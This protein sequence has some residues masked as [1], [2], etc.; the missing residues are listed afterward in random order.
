MLAGY[1]KK[2][3]PQPVPKC[4]PARDN[5]SRSRRAARQPVARNVPPVRDWAIIAAALLAGAALAATAAGPATWAW[6]G[7]FVAANFLLAAVALLAWRRDRL[8]VAVVVGV[9]LILRAF[10][11]PL[12]P[13]LS[14]DLWRYLWDGHVQTHGLSPYALRP[15]DVAL[16][17]GWYGRM[18]SP[19]YFSVYPPLSQFAFLPGG[20]AAR[21]GGPW[22]GIYAIKLVM[23]AAE[24]TALL[25]LSRMVPA[26]ALLLYAWNPVI[27]VECAGQGHTEA[28]ML[29]LL[30]GAVWCARLRSAAAAAACGGLVGAAVMVKLYPALLLPLAWRRGGWPAV[31]ASLAVMGLLAWPYSDVQNVR[32]A[33]E[34]LA[35]YSSLFEFNAWPY[36]L[37]RDATGDKVLATRA[38]QAA[39]VVGTLCIYFFDWRGR[40]P[41][42]RAVTWVLGLY[43]VTATTVHPWY[44]LGLLAMPWA[45]AG[46]AW[47]WLAFVVLSAGTYLRY[48]VPGG[49]GAYL[50]FSIAAWLALLML[51]PMSLLPTVMTIRGRRKAARIA[52][53]LP[54]GGRVLD[55]GC[56]EGHVG[57]ELARRGFAVTLADVADFRAVPLPF[58]RH[59]GRRL[60]FADGAFDAVVLYFVLHHAADAR[61]VLAE[62]MRIGRR[63]V[64]VESVYRTP[65]GLRVLTSLDK[66]A[67]RLR[68]GEQMADQEEHLHFRRAEE[69]SAMAADLG[70]RVVLRREHGKPPHRQATLVIDAPGSVEINS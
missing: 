34:S 69:W 43:V 44:V 32:N 20:L 54:A 57:G 62:A 22:A 58:V 60:P 49:E 30:V 66:A 55:L 18:H 3:R 7:S 59:D 42:D 19:D 6:R 10:V 53:H 50:A 67:N 24:V 28:L 39:L 11:L 65:L 70:G 8:T 64:V 27:V 40:Y 15:A 29:P 37:L 48:E 61:L 63:V 46:P 9:G 5:S 47:G 33:A 1:R 12:P 23:A 35:L 41:M 26:R 14:D 17:P 2:K 25:M 45:L 56:G 68:G 16:R 31:V 52:R 38:L 21:V 13:A 4:R 36:F 51:M